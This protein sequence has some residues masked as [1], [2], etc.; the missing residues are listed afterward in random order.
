MGIYE[1]DLGSFQ[2]TVLAAWPIHL[3]THFILNNL[4][5]EMVSLLQEASEKEIYY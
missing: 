2:F 3:Y 5:E 4:F 1:T